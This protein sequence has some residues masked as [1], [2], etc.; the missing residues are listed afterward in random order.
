MPIA[1]GSLLHRGRWQKILTH[2]P[3]SRVSAA[4]AKE[5]DAYGKFPFHHALEQ[6]APPSVTLEVSQAPALAMPTCVIPPPAACQS[7]ACRFHFQRTPRCGFSA[8]SPLLQVLAAYKD[9]AAGEISYKRVSSR[10]H[11]LSSKVV[12]D[13]EE[14]LLTL[15]HLAA[16][17][18]APVEVVRAILDINREAAEVKDELAHMRPLLCAT[19]KDAPV[20]VLRLL[21][22]AHPDAATVRRCQLLLPAGAFSALAFVSTRVR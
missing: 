4:A 11:A 8:H 22:E 17:H 5:I 7:L 21:M 1:Q 15:L 10:V 16:L 19:I 9:A 2:R 14:N 3:S 6:A 18:R 12:R 13:D 20:A